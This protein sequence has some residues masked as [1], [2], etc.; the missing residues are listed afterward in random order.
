MEKTRTYD[1]NLKT[2]MKKSSVRKKYR[3]TSGLSGLFLSV[4]CFSLVGTGFSSWLIGIGSA[5]A[6]PINVSV[7]SIVYQSV[8]LNDL[9]I[10]FDAQSATGLVTI[11]GSF[12]DNGTLYGGTNLLSN[13]FSI[14]GYA[15]MHKLS[16]FDLID[17]FFLRADFM[18]IGPNRNDAG[19]VNS[20]S[21]HPTNFDNFAF[22]TQV[23]ETHFDIE[24]GSEVFTFFFPIKT[25]NEIS[26]YFLA[27]LDSS[28]SP[29]YSAETPVNVPIS[30][31][32][33]L[34][35]DTADPDFYSS[36]LDDS[37][38]VVFS[39]TTGVETNG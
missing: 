31:C 8:D 32:F 29:V 36:N 14:Q 23:A 18:F 39:L 6:G 27:S 5:D 20:L 16:Q 17:D 28:F 26:L 9:G 22:T 21:V 35:V 19:R 11:S 4:G 2:G 12:S 25:K 30:F 1:Y 38:S 15:E 7:G 33:N 37:F 13:C 34:D 3:L 24:S 10:R